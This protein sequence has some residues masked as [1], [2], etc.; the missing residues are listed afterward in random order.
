IDL[1]IATDAA[2]AAATDSIDDALDYKAVVQSVT[3]LVQQGE[4]RLVETVA[5]RIAERIL[6][7]HGAS[8]VKVRV[9]KPGAIRGS[10]EVGV[11]IERSAG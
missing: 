8:W 2:R 7:D 1:E 9:A 4:F 11:I 6:G 3:E 10:R 5:E